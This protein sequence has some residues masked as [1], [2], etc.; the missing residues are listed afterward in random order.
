MLN[1]ILRVVLV[2]MIMQAALRLWRALLLARRREPPRVPPAGGVHRPAI[3]PTDII[4]A[5]YQDVGDRRSP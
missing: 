4:D 5:T 3:D 1:V 2:L